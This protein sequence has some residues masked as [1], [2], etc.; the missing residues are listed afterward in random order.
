MGPFDT[1]GQA[2]LTVALSIGKA[3]YN[4]E[5]ANIRAKAS[6]DFWQSPDAAKLRNIAKLC[7]V[8]RKW[9][10]LPQYIVLDY[11]LPVEEYVK[12]EL[13]KVSEP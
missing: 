7:N 12:A 5:L 1:E 6:R 10:R 9:G 2:R 4:R 3:A 13:A 8:L 11:L